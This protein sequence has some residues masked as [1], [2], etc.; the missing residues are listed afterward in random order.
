M[1]SWT[2]EQQAS[3]DKVFTLL[4]LRRVDQQEREH[5][6]ARLCQPHGEN[7]VCID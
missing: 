2:P 7:D 5:E 1:D 3:V 4:A 6:Q